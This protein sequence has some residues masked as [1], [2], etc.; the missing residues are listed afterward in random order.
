VDP[1]V[2][3]PEFQQALARWRKIPAPPAPTVPAPPPMGTDP[4]RMSPDGGP[5]VPA[6]PAER[7]AIPGYEILG[8]LGHGGM[9]V[10]YKARH[11]R[12]NRLVALKMIRNGGQANAEDLLRFL[13]EVETAAR[14]RHPHIVPIYEVARHDGR[15]YFTMEFVE[16]GNLA[17][18]I[19]GTP[20]PARPAAELLEALARAVHF[21]H[22]HKIVHRDL[23]P[24][25]VL[26]TADGMPK[27]TDF[28]LAKRLELGTGLTQT[29][30]MLGTPPYMAPEQAG[31]KPAAIGPATDVYALGAILY[32]LLT[33]R[34]PFVGETP[35]DTLQHVRAEEPVPPRRLQ[36]K[37][38]RDLETICLKCL[39][40]EPHKRYPS[41]AELAEDLQR[42]LSNQPIRARRTGVPERAW[43]WCRRNP[44]VASLVGSVALL[45]VLIAVG[46]SVAALLLAEQRDRARDGQRRAE[47]AEGKTRQAQEEGTKLWESYLAQARATRYG[48]QA[49]QRFKSLEALAKVAQQ[50]PSLELRNE[51]IAFMTLA[52]LQRV[53]EHSYKAEKQWYG[54]NVEPG[55]KHYS[56]GDEQGTIV[57][58]RAGDNKEVDRFPGSGMPA[59]GQR[60]SPDG[61]FLAAKYNL[62]GA[63]KHSRVWVWERGRREPLFKIPFDVGDAFDFSA[64]SRQLAVG[65]QDGKVHVYDLPGG[66]EA[67]P[68]I[69]VPVPR[70]PMFHPPGRTLAVY[71]GE[72]REVQILDLDAGK[73][74]RHVPC[75]KP[76]NGLAWHPEGKR[77]AAA[78]GAYPDEQ[79][80]I[81]VWDTATWGEPLVLRGHGA[82]VRSV[83]FSHGGDLL[84]SVAWD[85]SARLWDPWT[86]RHLITAGPD[87]GDAVQFRQDDR[88]LGTA[89]GK[90]FVFWEVNPGRE[91]RALH[92]HTGHK[93]P[94]GVDF[95]SDGR[96]LVS[97]GN[98]GVRLWDTAAAWEVAFLP[99]EKA[100]TAL[101]HP[102]GTRLITCGGSGLHVWP[103]GRD[104]NRA[105]GRLQVGPSQSPLKLD[106]SD[107][108]RACLA[109]DGCT[110]AVTDHAR[111]QVVVLD[112]KTLDAEP[113][114][115]GHPNVAYVAI[116]P[117][118]RWVA[119]STYMGKGVRVWNLRNRALVKELAIEDKSLAFSPDGKWLVTSTWD[120][121]HFWS[122]ESWEAG[123]TIPSGGGLDNPLAFTRDGTLLAITTNMRSVR[124]VDPQTRHEIATLTAPDPQPIS[125]LC[126]SPDGSQLAAATAAHVIHLWD[127]RR[128]R[129]QLAEM[130]LDWELPP[131]RSAKGP[132]LPERPLK[133]EILDR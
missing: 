66:K 33:G 63:E 111:G 82:E 29:G 2:D 129:Q 99:L 21:A 126:F 6:T 53:G 119:T 87:G 11:M 131:Y 81:Y 100:H 15:P 7:P 74:I 58:R 93:G 8:V 124:L 5:A 26:L 106:P 39:Q 114:P 95:S 121:Y 86:G 133:V 110:L 34:P 4:T 96:L 69:P 92:G 27:I 107:R 3:E 72:S 64:D 41:A 103:I 130:N 62:P 132:G 54:A 83:A 59:Y 45:L 18:K 47:D 113:L 105:A 116:S 73:V 52:D 32:E 57:I 84:A 17:Q 22:G 75:P 65:S 1:F 118:S 120:E 46:S 89:G 112:L 98:E 80:P 37:V 51:A 31:G 109:P 122:T 117:D 56:Y 101:V 49:G 60:F 94:W 28:G 10:V 19:K 14:L 71:S 20:Q 25:N 9:G 24:D 43:R 16:G 97:A 67:K 50:R 35:W 70:V 44:A 79:F 61:K 48:N 13:G 125:W 78:C 128:I 76:A 30:A 40:K 127:L 23:K 91:C 108:N 104:P 123:P 55:L 12:L 85:G 68:P 90:G 36:P 88:A 115:G 102:N 38:P 42:V 77:L